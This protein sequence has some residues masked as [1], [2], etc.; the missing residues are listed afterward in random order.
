MMTLMMV[1]KGFQN[2]VTKNIDAREESNPVFLIH[3]K[4]CCRYTTCANVEFGELYNQK[5]DACEDSNPGH[6]I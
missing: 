6:L 5:N 2:D 3:S 1:S 4:A